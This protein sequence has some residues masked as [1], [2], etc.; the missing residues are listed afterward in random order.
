VF[1]IELSLHEWNTGELMLPQEIEKERL[2][3][4]TAMTVRQ[5]Q[6]SSRAKLCRPFLFRFCDQ[7]AF[8]LHLVCLM[9]GVIPLVARGTILS[10]N[11]LR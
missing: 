2:V 6:E 3:P 7:A 9:T 10:D 1:E 4:P 11:I 8:E 5:A